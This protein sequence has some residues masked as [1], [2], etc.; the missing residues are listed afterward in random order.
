MQTGGIILFLRHGVDALCIRYAPFIFQGRDTLGTI[1]EFWQ[2]R[3]NL[4]RTRIK[5]HLFHGVKS[6]VLEMP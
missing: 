3:A 4:G 6:G 5:L 2:Q 1:T